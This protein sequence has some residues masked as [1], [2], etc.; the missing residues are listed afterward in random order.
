MNAVYVISALAF[1]ALLPC[2]ALLVL[3]LL[4]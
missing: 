2:F 4:G 1:S 3:W